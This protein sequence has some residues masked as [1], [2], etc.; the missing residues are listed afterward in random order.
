METCKIKSIKK[1]I[2]KENVYDI[3]NV[4]DHHNFVCNDMVVSN[5]DESINFACVTGDTLIL[6]E[7]GTN[8][9]IIELEHKRNFNVWTFNTSTH[10]REVKKAFGCRKIRKEKVF[11]VKLSTGERIRCT[12]DH[13]FLIRKG[14]EYK[15]LKDIIWG[16]YIKKQCIPKKFEVRKTVSRL[17]DDTIVLFKEVYQSP[18]EYKARPNSAYIRSIIPIG[19]E[20]VYEIL[21]V[22]DNNNYVS[23]NMM[24][25]NSSEDWAKAE[26]KELKKK[27]G[28]VRT[29]H[30]LFILCFPLKIQKVDKVYLENYVNYWIDLFGR[31]KGALYVKDNNPAHDSWRMKDFTKLGAYSEFTDADKIQNILSRHPNFWAMLSFP[32]PSEALYNKYLKVREL[33]VYDNPSVLSTVTNEDLV[34]AILIMSLKEIMMR[35]SSLSINRLLL[36]LQNTYEIKINRSVF[37][38]VLKDS[39]MLV[40]KVKETNMNKMNDK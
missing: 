38:A 23:N 3:V 35:D 2:K 6:L 34:R 10:I 5:C 24:S 18:P 9:P 30:L 1:C 13:K 14:M 37:D 33:N 39:K 11:E 15:K 8:V 4:G 17:Y 28:Q 26:N 25:R 27:L 29:K 31:G 19:K 16:N 22:E 40:D 7:D 36:H 12:K 32:K 21:G 20:D